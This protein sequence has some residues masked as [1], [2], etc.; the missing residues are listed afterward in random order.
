MRTRNGNPTR[1]DFLRTAAIAVAAPLILPARAKGANDRVNLAV[2]GA[3]RRGTQVMGEFLPEADIE[4]VAV[5]NVMEEWR[6]RAAQAVNTF[7]DRES[8][9]GGCA[10]YN[11][12]REVLE[13][14]DVDAVLIAPQDHWHALMATA[15]AARGKDIYCEKPLGVSVRECQLIR[16]AVRKNNVIFQTGTQQRSGA[17]F[18]LACELARNGYLGDLHTVEVAAPGPSY[19]REYTGDTGPQPVPPGFDYAMYVGPAPMKPYN[20]GRISWPDWYLIWDYCAGFIV[21]WGVHHLD[22]ALWGCP[23]LAEQPFELTCT[24]DYRNDGL[25]DNINGWQAEYVYN[26][27]LRMSFS[28]T[29]HPH[30]QGCRFVGSEGW[31]HVNR[32][33]IKSEPASLLEIGFGPDDTRLHASD[34]HQHDF[35]ASV[36]SRRD[37][38]APVESGLRASYFGMIADIAGRLQRPLQFDPSTERFADDDIANGMC[39]RP[40]RAPWVL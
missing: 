8:G 5:C 34:H 1:R 6:E 38:V 14:D 32:Q 2:L 30:E 16:E 29:G 4:V 17:D 26:D 27:G 18:R 10:K 3:G 15:A 33:G 9:N 20:E 28:D 37:P 25:T 22:I 40:M 7:Y 24:A 19:Q 11:D 31:V 23:R 21:N 39:A 35:V 12:F 13:R 36:K